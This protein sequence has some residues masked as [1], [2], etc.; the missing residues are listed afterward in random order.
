LSD[1]LDLMLEYFASHPSAVMTHEHVV[2]NMRSTLRADAQFSFDRIP[3]VFTLR[4]AHPR[5]AEI[6]ALLSASI[7]QQEPIDVV[8]D[9]DSVE[10]VAAF[11]M[12]QRRNGPKSDPFAALASLSNLRRETAIPCR[13]TDLLLDALGQIERELG[14][15]RQCAPS[16]LH[17]YLD[18][19]CSLCVLLSPIPPTR[20]SDV[21]A[22]LRHNLLRLGHDGRPGTPPC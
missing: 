19:V 12:A 7:A 6:D 15:I 10:I 5:F 3:S 17:L 8:I 1:D 18:A 9:W 2:P 13:D 20:D 16:T 22:L 14:R 11:S 4:R 21:F